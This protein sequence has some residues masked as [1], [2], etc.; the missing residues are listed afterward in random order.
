MSLKK[1][2]LLSAAAI[3][4][5]AGTGSALAAPPLPNLWGGFYAGGNVGYSWGNSSLKYY[6]NEA[7][8][9]GAGS[10]PISGS[11]QLDGAIGGFQAG[12]NWQNQN[13][14]W[15]VEAD[16]Q[17]SD[18]SGSRSFNYPYS[19]S[20]ECEGPCLGTAVLSG[21]LS[22]K[23]ESFGTLR[24][25]GGFLV[26]PT[27]WI[28][29]TGGLA[30]G[31]V[32]ASGHFVDTFDEDAETWSFSKSA[33]NV[34][35]VLGAGIEAFIPNLPNWTWKLEYLYI[36]LGSLSGSGYDS[37]FGGPYYWNANFTDNII[38]VGVNYHWH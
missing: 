5:I 31:R 35:W 7:A 23:I 18:E 33:T 25:R 32:N 10:Y 17:F 24:A 6:D 28:Y 22:S 37:D 14:V 3:A 4:M 2:L 38:R 12:Y 16:F 19:Y 29:A 8:S 27:T 30:F 15:G 1:K 34:G 20:D 26:N 11:S 21:S 9:Y 13:W 36:D